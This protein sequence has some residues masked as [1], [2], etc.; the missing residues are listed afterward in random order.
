MNDFLPCAKTSTNLK[1]AYSCLSGYGAVSEVGQTVS[2]IFDCVLFCF[3]LENLR[4]IS[5]MGMSNLEKTL[6]RTTMIWLS[7]FKALGSW[8]PE[9]LTP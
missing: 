8:N 7:L 1:K 5:E 3:V 9:S 2:V 4:L 6:L